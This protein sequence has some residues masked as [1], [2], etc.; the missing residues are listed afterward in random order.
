MHASYRSGPVS[1][2]RANETFL[3]GVTWKHLADEKIPE[4]IGFGHGG[5]GLEI[6]LVLDGAD[7]R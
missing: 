6:K 7:K 2:N 1:S 5:E 3:L 4:I